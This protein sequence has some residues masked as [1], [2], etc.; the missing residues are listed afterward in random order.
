[1]LR[2]RAD[3]R[4]L[5]FIAL[6]FGGAGCLWL[7]WPTMPWGARL[8]A[9]AAMCAISW[10]NAVITHNVLHAP[11][12]HD[13]RLNRLTQVVLSLTYG[14]PVSEYIPGHNLSHHRYMQ[15]RRDVMRTSKARFR[16]HLLNLL[17]FFFIVGPDV[18]AAN[19]YYARRTRRRNPRWFRQLLLEASLT[20]GIKVAALLVDWRRALFIVIVPHAW[21]VWG[22]TTVNLLQHDGCDGDHPYNHSRNFV[23]RIFNWFTFNN[24]YHGMHHEQPGLHWSLLPEAHAAIMKPNMDPRLDEPSLAL[25]LFRTFVW[26]GKRVRYDGSPV[27]LPPEG[28]DEDWLGPEN[29]RLLALDDSEHA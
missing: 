4:T 16:I 15:T 13:R 12:W 26:P 25:Y 21:A 20:W 22:I 2:H 7:L 23:G 9:V 18:T 10:I 6:Y 24:G 8:P 14:F 29:S 1:M 3:V 27:V 5:L 28:P 17:C 11:L 19:A